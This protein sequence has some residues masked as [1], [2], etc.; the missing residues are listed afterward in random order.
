MTVLGGVG[1]VKCRQLPEILGA[2]GL[3]EKSRDKTWSH[4][5]C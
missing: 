1:C 2:F 3:E 5:L 4:V